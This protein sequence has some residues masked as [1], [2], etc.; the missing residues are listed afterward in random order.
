MVKQGVVYLVKSKVS[1]VSFRPFRIED[2]RR[3]VKGTW[4]GADRP[5]NGSPSAMNEGQKGMM[6]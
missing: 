1:N 4:K 3:K 2:Q 5:K 6:L